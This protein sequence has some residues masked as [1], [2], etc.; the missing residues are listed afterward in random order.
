MN[1]K[2]KQLT[3]DILKNFMHEVMV[4]RGICTNLDTC[5]DWGI[6]ITNASTICANPP[7]ESPLHWRYAVVEVMKRSDQIYQ[8]LTT[9][10]G[11][12]FRIWEASESPGPFSVMCLKQ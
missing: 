11:V 8:R 10:D 3:A 6:Y 9:Y 1:N 2:T 12:F 4:Y 7:A 5:T